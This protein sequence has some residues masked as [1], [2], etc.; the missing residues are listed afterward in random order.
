VQDH[1]QRERP[2]ELLHQAGGR[3]LPVKR[4]QARD[5]IGQAR[6][7]GLDADLDVVE[8]RVAELLRAAGRETEPAGDEVRVQAQV[9]GGAHDAVEV[10]AQQRLAAGEVELQDAEVPALGQHPLPFRRGQ[11]LSVR[12]QVERVGAVRAVQRAAVGELGQQAE[13]AIHRPPPG[14]V[15]R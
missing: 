13:R 14:I 7:V 5:A 9:A 10:P 1:V 11:L 8:A 3:Y 12:V 6:L 4:G 2:A 15:W